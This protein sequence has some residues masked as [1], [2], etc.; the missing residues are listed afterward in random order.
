MAGVS[1]R[2]FLQ[3]GRRVCGAGVHGRERDHAR[4]SLWAC[5]LGLRPGRTGHESG[6]TATR[7]LRHCSGH[8]GFVSTPSS[9]SR[10]VVTLPVSPTASR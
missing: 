3:S 5:R 7:V 2:D 4:R 8:E 10:R 9:S 6:P 1:R